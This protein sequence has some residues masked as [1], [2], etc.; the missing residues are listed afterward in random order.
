MY[1]TA[2]KKMGNS[3]EGRVTVLVAVIT[4]GLTLILASG[5]REHHFRPGASLPPPERPSRIAYPTLSS[6]AILQALRYAIWAIAGLFVLALL[7]SKGGRRRIM[8]VGVPIALAALLTFFFPAPQEKEVSLQPLEVPHREVMAG[9]NQI[10]AEP[11]PTD[12]EPLTPPMLPPWP[13]FLLFGGLMVALALGLFWTR[14]RGKPFEGEKKASLPPP[15]GPNPEGMVAQAWWRM[16]EVLAARAGM[17]GIPK[18]RT[19]RE[20]AE[21]FFQRF[22]HPAIWELTELFEEVRY[23]ERLDAELAGKA[24]A[25]LAKIEELE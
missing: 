4:L 10:P 1:D 7:F 18:T 24:R 12:P 3:T 14:D 25:A 5:L 2:R 19:A 23:G 17:A 21:F 11:K 20:L 6:D 15:S 8:W 9:D 22:S 13:F 16:V